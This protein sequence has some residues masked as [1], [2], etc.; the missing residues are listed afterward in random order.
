MSVNQLQDTGAPEMHFERMPVRVTVSTLG[1]KEIP[2]EWHNLSIS[3]L[4]V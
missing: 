2:T 4:G 1:S 3:G